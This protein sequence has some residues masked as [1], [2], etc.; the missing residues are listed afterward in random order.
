MLAIL[1]SADDLLMSV[2]ASVVAGIAVAVVVS[3]AIW[4]AVKYVDFHDE[5]RQ[6]AAIGALLTSIVGLLLTAAIIVTGIGLM[7]AG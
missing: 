1:V 4:G 5:G 6:T 2:A 3:V 7:V